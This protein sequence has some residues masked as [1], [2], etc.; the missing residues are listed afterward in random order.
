MNTEHYEADV[1]VSSDEQYVIFCSERPGGLGKGDLYISFNDNSGKRQKAK[2][3][4]FQDTSTKFQYRF[5]A[6]TDIPLS[7]GSCFFGKSN[8]NRSIP[9]HLFQHESLLPIST[10]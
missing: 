9:C 2:N 5:N 4:R 3:S 6:L 7:N 8:T 10:S 1:F